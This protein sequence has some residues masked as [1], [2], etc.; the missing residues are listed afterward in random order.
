MKAL[1]ALLALALTGCAAFTEDTA[2]TAD[3]IQAAAAFYPLAYAADRVAGD[4]ATVTN[5]TTPGGEPHD[6]ELTPQETADVVRA[7][8][9]VYLPGFQPSVDDAVATNATGDV[10]DVADTVDVRDD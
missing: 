9:V 5:L 4:H 3:G 1:V 10:L 8:L 7:D 6:L 2:S